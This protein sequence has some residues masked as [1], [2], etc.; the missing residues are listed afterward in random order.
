MQIAAACGVQFFGSRD[1]ACAASWCYA[2]IPPAAPQCSVYDDWDCKR[3][4]S[5]CTAFEITTRRFCR[6]SSPARS[7]W[8]RVP[9]SGIKLSKAC[10]ELEPAK[11]AATRRRCLIFDLE[12]LDIGRLRPRRLDPFDHF[13]QR[14]DHA[15]IG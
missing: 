12:L 10:P 15:G 2:K 13:R 8:P 6:T 5:R 7:R 11:Q 3:P 14:H 9:A 1:T 4:R